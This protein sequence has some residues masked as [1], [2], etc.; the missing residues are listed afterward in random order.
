MTF[1]VDDVVIIDDYLPEGYF[2]EM[3][4]MVSA[5]CFPWSYMGNITNDTFESNL[6]SF[7]FD[8]TM[9]QDGYVHQRTE[10][11]IAMGCIQSIRKDIGAQ[12]V[13][14]ARY[15]MTLYNPENYRHKPHVDEDFG[16]QYVSGILYMNESDGNTVIYEET[17]NKI[18]E[19]IDKEYTIKKEIEP[20]PNRLA[21]FPCQHV[22]TGHSPSKHR[23][24]I[25]L[26]MLFAL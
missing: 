20:K 5:S 15:D 26:N 7:G 12:R 8:F 10:T 13:E 17:S 23:N 9:I 25:L 11:F 21:L 18:N 14:K 3:Q 4:N 6:A 2:E 22:H 24:R 19:V 16:E 1:K